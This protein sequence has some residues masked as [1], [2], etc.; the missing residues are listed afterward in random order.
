MAELHSERDEHYGEQPI[1]VSH[2]AQILRRYSGVILMTMAAV[3]LVYLIIGAGAYL[4]SSQQKVISM[5]FRL[6]FSGGSSGQYPNGLK[7]SVADITATPVLLD[8]FNADE[9]ARFTTVDRFSRS[10][11]VL[12]SNRELEQLTREYETKLADPKLTPVDRDRLEREFDAKRAGLNKSDY[13]IQFLVTPETRD[14][15]QSVIRKA[16]ADI[17]ATWARRAAIEKKA[18]DYQISIVGPSILDNMRITGNDYLIPLLLLRQRVDTITA[19]AA[20]VANMPGAKL[21]RTR[22]GK[23]SI[24]EVQL[25]LGEIIR[26]RL[27]PLIANARAAGMFGSNA[28]ALEV[29]KAQLAYDQR[30]LNSAQMRQQALQNALLTYQS[31]APRQSEAAAATRSEP[32][33]TDRTAGETVMPQLS[34]TFLDRIVDLTNR[35]ADREYRQKLTDDIK[36]ASLDVVPVQAAVKYDQELIDSFRTASPA[37]G[38]GATA[39]LKSQWDVAVSE[40]RDA[41]VDLNQI[42]NLASK[43]LYPETEM[44]R[45]TAP[46][47]TRV[48]RSLTPMRLAL[49]G[50]LVF[51]I[52]LPLTIVFVLLHNRIREEEAEEAREKAATG[53]AQHAPATA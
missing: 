38:P 31:E 32:S 46:P 7:F 4:M 29:L 41:V 36:Q 3:V 9:L 35:T 24:A 37:G 33:G 49:Y 23:T 42:Y 28:M 47:S 18:L 51:L 45:V 13:A 1:S 21:V 27:E 19:N 15:P 16:L 6:E 26:F 2:L 48:E 8:V 44:Y 11:Y 52:A 43:Q 25:R 20:A 34:D 50:V 17:L 39:D 5:P 53:V 40:V 30:Q 22:G 10:I 12:E 14:I